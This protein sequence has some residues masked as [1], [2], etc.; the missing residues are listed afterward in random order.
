MTIIISTY[1]L[2]ISS[3]LFF[4]LFNGIDT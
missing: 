2:M 4:K 3:S 1:Q